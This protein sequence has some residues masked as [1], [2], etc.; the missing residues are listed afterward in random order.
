MLK[1]IWAAM[2]KVLF[3]ICTKVAQWCLTLCDAMDCSPPGSS[4]HGFLQSRIVEWITMPSSRVRKTQEMNPGLLHL[5][6][7]LYCLSYQGSQNTITSVFYK[8]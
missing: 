2:T 1:S 5:S 8:Q 4:F 6:Q 3:Y 7:V